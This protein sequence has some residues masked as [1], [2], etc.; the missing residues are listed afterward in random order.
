MNDER[1]IMAAEIILSADLM[2]I[3]KEDNDQCSNAKLI[4]CDRQYEQ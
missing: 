2:N 4:L 1:E 3:S